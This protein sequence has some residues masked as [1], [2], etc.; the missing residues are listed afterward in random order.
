M[1]DFIGCKEVPVMRCEIGKDVKKL[2]VDLKKKKSVKLLGGGV[3][4]Y[5][6]SFYYPSIHFQPAILHFREQVLRLC[7]LI[8]L[9]G[10]EGMQ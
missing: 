9:G 3:V 4:C 6:K 5:L 10:G 7:R 8:L 1:A 2:P